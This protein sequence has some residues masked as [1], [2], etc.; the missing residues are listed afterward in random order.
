M[1]RIRLAWDRVAERSRRGD[2]RGVRQD[3]GQIVQVRARK[4]KRV[5]G[6][7]EAP[8][9][10]RG[11]VVEH[12]N[13][14]VGPAALIG[15]QV[16]V[17][18]DFPLLILG[19][20]LIALGRP[21]RF[22]R[23]PGQRGQLGDRD[24][25]EVVAPGRSVLGV[26]AVEIRVGAGILRL[27]GVVIHRGAEAAVVEVVVDV[28]HVAVDRAVRHQQ[29]RARRNG[30]EL[31]PD[32][33]GQ[34]PAGLRGLDGFRAARRGR[35][36][37]GNAPQV[38]VGLHRGIKIGR[39]LRR[40][41]EGA[42]EGAGGSVV[43]DGEIVDF[44]RALDGKER[45]AF[46]HLV[47]EREAALDVSVEGQQA[48]F[49]PGRLMNAEKIGDDLR[50]MGG[51][52]PE[53]ANTQIGQQR[54]DLCGIVRPLRDVRANPSRV[55]E[56]TGRQGGGLCLRAGGIR[57]KRNRDQQAE[58]RTQGRSGFAQDSHPAERNG[59]QQGRHKSSENRTALRRG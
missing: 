40:R 29:V 39:E 49:R 7:D 54:R 3:G 26:K 50:V 13:E 46:R 41:Q 32:V 8:G 25:G 37:H 48:E 4:L 31:Q 35:A 42:V 21:T 22:G 58:R 14:G 36:E 56:G 59:E 45:A 2:G 20:C 51:I 24:A 6:V 55:Q 17:H 47:I 11:I 12:V 19:Q 28:G 27:P 44:I 16:Q 57:Q 53:V 9:T 52:V 23:H 38:T 1:H 18:V 34:R 43:R 30:E 5:V 15:V 10:L 33:I